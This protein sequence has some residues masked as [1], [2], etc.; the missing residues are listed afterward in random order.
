[1]RLIVAFGLWFCTSSF[2]Y[3]IN[4]LL[5]QINNPRDAN[6]TIIDHIIEQRT[7]WLMN[8]FVLFVSNY[9]RTD[10]CDRNS[11]NKPTHYKGM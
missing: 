10:S 4:L 3:L 11:T 5:A 9:E 7:S 8:R 1:V 6:N 2:K